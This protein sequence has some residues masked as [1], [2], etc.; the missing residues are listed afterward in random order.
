MSSAEQAE[1]R[2]STAAPLVYSLVALTLS[3]VCLW[4][5]TLPMAATRAGEAEL[6]LYAASAVSPAL[7]PILEK[8]TAEQGVRTSMQVGPSGGLE[9]QIR[10]S[11]VGD[12]YIPAATDP[13]LSRLAQEGIVTR[14]VPLARL[15]LVLAYRSD[16]PLKTT[17]LQELVD[18]GVSFGLCNEQAAAGQRTRAVLESQGLWEEVSRSATASMMTVA[19]L[20]SAV[21]DGGRLRA[22]IVWNT[23]AKQFGLQMIEPPELAEAT[24]SIGVGVLA[25]SKN[26]GLAERLA[27][28]LAAPHGGKDLLIERGYSVEPDP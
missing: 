4:W 21:R 12:L 11:G 15:Q 16:S 23:T 7:E 9:T 20:A 13:F 1:R 10:L 28:Y 26:P 5:L 24:A 22:G 8:F 19:E 3:V 17:T 25:T 6:T 14:V 18:E 27:S 2:G